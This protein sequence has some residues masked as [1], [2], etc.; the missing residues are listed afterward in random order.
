MAKENPTPKPPQSQQ[1][2]RKI[3]DG[4]NPPQP[5]IKPVKK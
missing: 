4:K 2:P 3:N 1:A 5:P